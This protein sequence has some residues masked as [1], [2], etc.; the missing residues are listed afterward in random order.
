MSSLGERG[1]WAYES[2]LEV[3]VALKVWS[4]EKGG[5]GKARGRS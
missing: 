2:C 3:E 5:K 1:A 4:L